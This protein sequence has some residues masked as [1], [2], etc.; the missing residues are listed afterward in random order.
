MDFGKAIMDERRATVLEKNLTSTDNAD[1][2]PAPSVRQALLGPWRVF[3]EASATEPDAAG[4][5]EKLVGSSR[6]IDINPVPVPSPADFVEKKP[7]KKS[8]PVRSGA[9]TPEVEAGAEISVPF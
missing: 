1:Y 6:E 9:A 5:S 8:K 4:K 7:K 3:A 2:P